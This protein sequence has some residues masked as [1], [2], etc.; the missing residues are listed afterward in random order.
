MLAAL[1]LTL[2]QAARRVLPLITVAVAVLLD[3][4]P[5][6]TLAADAVRPSVTIVAVY[7]WT[8]YRP[9]LLGPV[10]LFV[11]GVVADAIAGTPVGSMSLMLLAIRLM[12]LAPQRV[13]LARS[14]M[15]GWLGFAVVTFTLQVMR[16]V[17]ACLYV[18]HL[19]PIET[20]IVSSFLT[21][22]CYPPVALLLGRANGQIDEPQHAAGS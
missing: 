14:F 2:D 16:W 17:L 9:A 18:W 1:T 5:L 20:V 12:V 13:L 8:L 7:F 10:T 19:F 15:G 21:I 4:L 6:T 22:A 3:L 11:L